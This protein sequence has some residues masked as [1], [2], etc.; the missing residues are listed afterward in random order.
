MRIFAITIITLFSISCANFDTSNIA[1]G[2]RDAFSSVKN[3]LLSSE[4]NISIELIETIPY[5]SA[6]L[7]IGR[8]PSGLIILESIRED[9][10]NWISADGVIITTDVYGKIIGTQGLDNNLLDIESSL[11][12]LNDID[13]QAKYTCFYSFDPPRL[14]FL[15][16]DINYQAKLGLV[17]LIKGPTQ[18]TLIQEKITS[19]IIGWKEINKYWID[20]KGFIWKSEQNISPKLP[21]FYLEI[22]KKPAT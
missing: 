19:S 6:K 16:V 13:F 22:T 8:G 12:S 4:D 3:Y 17:E 2:Y 7:R 9:K 14:N 20:D 5:A 21:T 1:P 10:Y 15:P 18:L 11:D